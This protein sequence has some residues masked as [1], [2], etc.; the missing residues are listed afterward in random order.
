M[1]KGDYLQSFS[2]YKEMLAIYCKYGYETWIATSLE[3]LASVHTVASRP[4]Q[5]ARLFGAA[6]ILR[7]ASGQAM[8]P[9]EII[10]YEISLQTL[11]LQLDAVPFAVLW[12]EGRAMS[13]E[14]AVVYA[15]AEVPS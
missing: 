3:K 10:D 1:L 7:E 6:Q 5:A 2:C 14:Q 12:N 11:H 9:F 4:E 13:M 15:Q 8:F